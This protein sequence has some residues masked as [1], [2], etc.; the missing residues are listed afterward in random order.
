[1]LTCIDPSMRSES[2]TEEDDIADVLSVAEPHGGRLA[3]RG[4]VARMSSTVSI[5][6]VAVAVDGPDR[7]QPAIEAM[8]GAC[9]PTG[10]PPRIRVD[11]STAQLDV[12]GRRPDASL[13]DIERWFD[14]SGA[15]ARHASGAVGRRRGETVSVWVPPDTGDPVR[16]FRLATQYPLIDALGLYGRHALHAALIER[17]GHA[18]LAAGGTGA[19]KSTFAFAAA[20]D[21]WS[22]LGDDVALIAIDNGLRAWGFPKSLN[23]PADVLGPV[24]REAVRIVGDRRERWT[25]PSSGRFRH[26]ACTLS[27]LVLLGHSVGDARFTTVSPTPL[28]LKQ[29]ALSLGVGALRGDPKAVFRVAGALARTSTYR[30]EHDRD[31]ARRPAA[32]R[33]FLRHLDLAGPSGVG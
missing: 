29:L 4:I 28:L 5:G 14:L 17:N 27:H 20:V 12:P 16:S 13:N 22:V 24:P 32:V 6:D 10:D 15:T 25:V 7:L 11:I 19:G 1:M 3:N 30:F 23:I 2:H 33:S 26:G 31:K 18:I 21:R 8:F 9:P